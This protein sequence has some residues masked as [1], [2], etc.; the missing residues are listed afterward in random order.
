MVGA[1]LFLLD[2]YHAE[3][4]CNAENSFGGKT[5]ISASS[6]CEKRVQRDIA[7]VREDTEFI[8]SSKILVH[9]SLQIPCR[10]FIASK[11][12]RSFQT[13]V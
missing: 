8:G 3:L 12:I 2:S 13:A 1:L 4:L 6:Q 5:K 10:F 9:I 11:T 7:S